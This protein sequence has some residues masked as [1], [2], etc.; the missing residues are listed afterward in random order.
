M[1]RRVAF[2]VT[3]RVQGVGFRASTIA[4]AYRR[5][6][7]G[8]VRN[9]ADGDVEGEAQGANADVEAFRNWLQHGPPLARVERVELHEL[10]GVDA[11]AAFDVRR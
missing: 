2:L 5:H 7:T 8:F 11:E 4:E 9:R 6:L 1:T 3:G 10:P